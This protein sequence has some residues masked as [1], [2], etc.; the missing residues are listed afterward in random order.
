V[1]EGQLI[2]VCGLDC[3]A[4][5]LYRLPADDEAAER[6]V[7]WFRDMDWLAQDEGLQEVLERSLYCRGC[8]GDRSLHWSPDCWI[9]EC[10]VDERGHTYCSECEAFPC[11]RLEERAAGSERYAQ[12]LA[13]LKAMRAGAAPRA[14]GG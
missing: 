12:G 7:S 9:L 11:R 1:D 13:R 10:C 5:D 8:R 6:V 3:A 2:A 14:A 4:C